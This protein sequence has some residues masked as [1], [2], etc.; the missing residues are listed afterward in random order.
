[1]ILFDQT[2]TAEAASS[3][4]GTNKE[5]VMGF[6]LINSFSTIEVKEFIQASTCGVHI[7]I[8]ELSYFTGIWEFFGMLKGWDQFFFSGPKKKK[9]KE[10]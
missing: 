5:K 6:F 9:K 1:M 8:K 3:V 2:L 10:K 4:K 7:S